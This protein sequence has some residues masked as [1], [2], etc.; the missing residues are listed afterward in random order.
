MY[1]IFTYIDLPNHPNVGLYMAYMDRLGT[2]IFTA[3]F[4]PRHQWID[5][6]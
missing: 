1:G 6:A 2:I 3:T 4:L 5:Q